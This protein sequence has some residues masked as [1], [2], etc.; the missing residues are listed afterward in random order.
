[1]TPGVLSY[2]PP[3]KYFLISS[4]ED[5]SSENNGVERVVGKKKDKYGNT[6]YL[7]R[8]NGSDFIWKPEETLNCNKLIEEYEERLKSFLKKKTIPELP[9]PDQNIKTDQ[10]IKAHSVEKVVGKEEGKNGKTFYLVKWKGLSQFTR[11]PEENLSCKK[12]IEEYDER[13]K[14]LQKTIPELPSPDQNTKSRTQPISNN[15]ERYLHNN[16]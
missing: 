2:I 13:M 10:N 4:E 16:S 1:M 12:L 7:V 14:S 9:Y 15:T 5:S 11:E 3:P 6:S 8:L